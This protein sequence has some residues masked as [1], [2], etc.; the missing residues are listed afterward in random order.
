MRDVIE[1][2]ENSEP[3]VKKSVLKRSQISIYWHPFLEMTTLPTSSLPQH[4]QMNC[5][6]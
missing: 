6:F 5:S 2:T 3:H 4:P 1:L